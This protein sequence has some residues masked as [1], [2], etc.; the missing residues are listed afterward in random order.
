MNKKSIIIIT[1]G[2]F[3]KSVLDIVS[4]DIKLFFRLPI[5]V[6][7]CTLDL[8]SFYSP[9][10]RQYD[11]NMLLKA[12]SL[13]SSPDAIKTIGLTR[14]DLFIPILTYIFGQSMLD[15][16]TGIVSLFRL[17]NELYGLE[18]NNFLLIE[19]F[20]KVV[21][22]ELAHAFG[23]IHCHNP[24]CIMRSSTYVEDLDQKEKQFCYRCRAELNRIE[25][26]GK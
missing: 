24:A 7:E 23:L 10:R 14:V 8:S 15:G 3:E 2:H 12:L 20:R 25:E 22:H 4:A 6:K 26:M 11:A 13:L 1:C 17:R 19:R 16:T 5:I 21:V 9:E 18:R